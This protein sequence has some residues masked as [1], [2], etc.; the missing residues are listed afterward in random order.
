MDLAL[1]YP[2]R[3][4]RAQDL[5]PAPGEWVVAD[6]GFS[7]TDRT[8]GWLDGDQA[9]LNRTF[10]EL[11]EALIATALRVGSPLNLVIEA[12]LSVAFGAAGNP[13]GRSIEKH[14]DGRHRYWHEGL[15]TTVL[16]SA[17]H[18][19]R[20]VVDARPQRE[21]RLFEG[22]VSFKPKGR[23]DHCRDVLQL[24]DIAW[25]RSA[26]GRI[27]WPDQLKRHPDDCLR[28]AFAVAGMDFGVP[29]VLI[30]G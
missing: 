12:P 4:G 14:D 20:A 7:S 8:C 21:I 15:G 6:V 25:G 1:P 22:F 24:V 30:T 18:L 27:V 13:A 29:P 26:S 23:S 11:Q 10:A 28:S 5:P 3:P 9:P 16:L 19:L 17:M 2:I